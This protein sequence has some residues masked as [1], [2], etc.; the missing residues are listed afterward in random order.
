MSIHEKINLLKSTTCFSN[1]ST[2]F[3]EPERKYKKSF[4]ESIKDSK[5]TIFNFFEREPIYKDLMPVISKSNK[6]NIVYHKFVKNNVKTER[7]SAFFE[8]LL[9]AIKNVQKE[10]ENKQIQK[11]KNNFRHYYIIPRIDI[12]RKKREKYE[13]YYYN[14]KNKTA[15]DDIQ[16]LKKS[17]STI[18][19]IKLKNKDENDNT[20]YKAINNFKT[21]NVNNITITTN[22]NDAFLSLETHQN[23]NQNNE[24]SIFN[25][26][27]DLS[28]YNL[29]KLSLITQPKRI[30]HS[31][32]KNISR[33]SINLSE[34]F[35]KQ[36]QFN[37]QK[38]KRMNKILDKCEE[39]LSQAKNIAEEFEKESK[40]KEPL[41]IINKFKNAMQSDDKKIIDG[42]ETGDKKYREYKRIQEEKFNNL[43]KNLDIKI[44]DEYAYKIR[45]EL[46]NIYGGNGNVLAYELYSKDISKFKE[47]IEKNLKNEKRM[48]NRVK[49]ML[50]DT[51]RKKEYLKYKID[52]YRMKQEKFNEI[53]NYDFKKKD[54]FE[55]NNY[56]NEELK[57]SLLPKLIELRE[58][59]HVGEYYNFNK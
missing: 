37:Y 46:Q 31:K 53:K 19:Q 52:I 42:I 15:D 50:D 22:A 34:Y 20:F 54:S 55:N 10:K 59:C 57:G 7:K 38:Y 41:D 47:K 33:K 40:Q 11:I 13:S 25:N 56:N 43:K 9:K 23:Y 5:N 4:H 26:L 36:E 44:S 16:F 1:M 27:K 30:Y 45:N 48:V 35:Q 21:N 12:L 28:N 17:R 2:R 58:Q 51:Y 32:S 49:N 24:G 14:K 8:G 6:G 3:S 39:S 18:N 29:T